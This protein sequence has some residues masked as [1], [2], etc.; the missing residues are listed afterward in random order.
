MRNPDFLKAFHIN[1]E[2]TPL[3]FE[4]SDIYYE[5]EDTAS[6]YLYPKLI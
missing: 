2:K 4:C 6:Y 3:W 5:R 1:T